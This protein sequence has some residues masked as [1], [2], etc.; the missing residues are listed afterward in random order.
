MR[1]GKINDV[2]APPHVIK[3]TVTVEIESLIND[4]LKETPNFEKDRDMLF[5]NARNNL[6]NGKECSVNKD[7]WEKK[8]DLLE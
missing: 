6:G 4:F 3:E 5:R 1:P 8:K 2:G 7:A